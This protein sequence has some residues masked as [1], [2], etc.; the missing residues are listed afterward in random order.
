MR[1]LRWIT[2]LLLVAGAGG[3][4]YKLRADWRSFRASNDPSGIKLRPLPPVPAPEVPAAK[5]YTVVAQQNPFH[6]ERNDALPPPPPATV[7]PA[8]GPPPL[9]YGSM[10][11]GA[12]KFALLGSDNDPRPRKVMQGEEFNGYK[13]AEVRPQSVVFEADGSKNEVMLY[14]ALTRL[15]RDS[16]RTQSPPPPTA[17]AATV[18]AS[19]PPQLNG[20]PVYV[21]PSDPPASPNVKPPAGRKLVMTPFG[22][23]WQDDK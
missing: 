16:A 12:E 4:G 10:I 18:G 15:R 1:K 9:V 8:L 20:V 22:P 2:V 14:N 6:P 17:T 3:L 21:P 11:L 13:L 23:M 5:D 19:S 7:K